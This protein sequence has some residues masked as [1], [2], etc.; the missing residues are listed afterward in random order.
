MRVPIPLEEDNKPT[1]A[2]E[3]EQ[4]EKQVVGDVKAVSTPEIKLDDAV[5]AKMELDPPANASTSLNPEA[6]PTAEP[7]PTA[8]TDDPAPTADAPAPTAAPRP[9]ETTNGALSEEKGD[10]AVLG[11]EKPAEGAAQVDEME[12]DYYEDRI[13]VEWSEVEL[14]TKVRCFGRSPAIRSPSAELTASSLP[15]DPSHLQHLP[16]AHGRR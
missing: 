1:S 8:A 16:L 13:D 7:L 12:L 14:E 5:D 9:A 3:Q 15:I 10:K 4:G 11:E 6:P 2:Q